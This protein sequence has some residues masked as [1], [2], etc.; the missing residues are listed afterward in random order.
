M[1]THAN[2]NPKAPA[3]PDN[4]SR[5]N[6]QPTPDGSP[7]PA[8]ARETGTSAAADSTNAQQTAHAA[9]VNS[10]IAAQPNPNQADTPAPI[11]IFD[12]GIGGFSVLRE[13]RAQL[14]GHPVL[15]YA[16][17]GNHPYGIRPLPEVREICTR[18]TAFL[19]SHGA[20]VVVI[21][22]NTA[23]A[24][25]LYHLRE[26]FPE[27]DFVGMEPALKPAVEASRSR[28][29]GILATA[30]TL[31]GQ[32][33]AGVVERFAGNV[34]IHEQACS[35]LAELIEHEAPREK[36]IPLLEAWLQPMRAAGVDQLALACT[37]YPLIIDLIRE[38]AGTGIRVIDPSPA[39]ARQTQRV[40]ATRGLL[41]DNSQDATGGLRCYVSAPT[42]EIAGALRRH[43]ATSGIIEETP[44][45]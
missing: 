45:L 7:V 43:C 4:F 6:P 28:H 22:C 27:T 31:R 37:H 23:S 12:S 18:I 1:M 3:S 13:I 26:S 15:Y 20:R 5:A 41:C 30:G 39:I 14:P 17:R 21:A 34:N 10:A 19:L 16:D 9:R 36:I 33:Y 32:P 29:V 11:G 24:A 44:V 40:L 42:P 2:Q 38:V 8:P 25:A 35:G